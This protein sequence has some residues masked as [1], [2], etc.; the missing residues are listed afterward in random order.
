MTH[1]G[2]T[3]CHWCWVHEPMNPGINRHICGGFRRYLGPDHPYRTDRRFGK[4]ER[5]EPPATR[6]HAEIIADSLRL[7]ALY[8]KKDKSDHVQESGVKEWCALSIL[9]LWNM[10]WDFLPDMMHILKGFFQRQLVRLFKSKRH[11]AAP[12]VLAMKESHSPEEQQRRR[13]QNNRAMATA[14]KAHDVRTLISCLSVFIR[15][16]TY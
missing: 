3:Y 12:S 16:N 7:D 8:T 2:H 14:V 9:P 11:P 10:V 15:I 5:R 1:K 6:Q 4:R 13:S